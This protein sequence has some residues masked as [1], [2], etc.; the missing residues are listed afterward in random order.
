MRRTLSLV[1]AVATSAVAFSAV[2]G[3]P[4]A[5]AATLTYDTTTGAAVDTFTVPPTVFEVGGQ[6]LRLSAVAGWK[7]HEHTVFGFRV[8]DI[9]KAVRG[10]KEKGVAPIVYPGFGQDEDGVWTAPGGGA[11]VAW[12]NDPDGN[13]LS[14]TEIG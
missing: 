14:V 12:F 5:T 7:A 11:R 2:S 8:D 1:A 3:T 4:V 9:G 13:N 6:M 10:L